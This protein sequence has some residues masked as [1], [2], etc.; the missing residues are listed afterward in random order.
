MWN[1]LTRTRAI[2]IWTAMVMTVLA[3]LV[4]L[5][6]LPLTPGSTLLLAIVVIVPPSVMLMVWRG[7]PPPTV[8]ETIEAADRRR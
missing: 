4:P 1:S 7:A 5:Q 2:G 6:I 8:A 3:I